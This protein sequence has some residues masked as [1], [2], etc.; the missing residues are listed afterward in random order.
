MLVLTRYI[1][2][3]ILIGDDIEVTVADVRGSQVRLGITAPAEIGIVRARNCSMRT[4]SRKAHAGRECLCLL[5][6]VFDRQEATVSFSRA[7]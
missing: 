1:G 3:T 2:E 5:S 7:W 6:Y 4:T